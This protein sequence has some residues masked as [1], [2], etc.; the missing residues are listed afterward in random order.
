MFAL[1]RGSGSTRDF[2]AIFNYEAP[3]GRNGLSNVVRQSPRSRW[4]SLFLYV[5]VFLIQLLGFVA[6]I[7]CAYLVQD[8][9]ISS[10]MII[11][12]L[13]N[14]YHYYYYFSDFGCCNGFQFGVSNSVV[15]K[16]LLSD[17]AVVLFEDAMGRAFFVSH[18]WVAKFH[19]ESWPN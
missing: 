16:E 8:I 9:I 6:Y 15:S 3:W 13:L 1:C 17:N 7:N 12:S 14:I 5:C 11:I 19:P 10:C 4:Q 18:Q 2:S